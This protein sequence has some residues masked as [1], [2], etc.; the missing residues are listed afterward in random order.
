M[1]VRSK[2]RCVNEKYDAFN[3]VNIVLLCGFLVSEFG[4]LEFAEFSQQK[5]YFMEFEF[6]SSGVPEFSKKKKV[7]KK[8]RFHY[9]AGLGI[10]GT[11]LFSL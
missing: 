10:N 11:P 7:K 6:R 9:E 2:E 4:V 5:V 1:G 3:I 8:S